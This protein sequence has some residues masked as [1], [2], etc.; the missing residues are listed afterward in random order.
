MIDLAD[1]PRD[2]V[3]DVTA[4]IQAAIDSGINR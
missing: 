1:I 2:G 3:T 4:L